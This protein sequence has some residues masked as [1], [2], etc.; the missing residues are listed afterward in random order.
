[1]NRTILCWKRKYV[2]NWAVFT[3]MEY[4]I[5]FIL[6]F[7]YLISKTTNSFKELWFIWKRFVNFIS[8]VS[9][10]NFNRVG[11]NIRIIVPNMWNYIIFCYFEKMQIGPKEEI[12]VYNPIQGKIMPR[13]YSFRIFDFLQA[14]KDADSDSTTIELV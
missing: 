4:P 14:L 12:P 1:M 9:N 6:F 7:R 11:K 2:V 8:Q 3:S 5:F 13:K 10:I